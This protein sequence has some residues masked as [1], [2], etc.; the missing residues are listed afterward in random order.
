MFHKR[1]LQPGQTLSVFVHDM[2]VL[3]LH[4]IPGLDATARDELLVYQFLSGL[5]ASVSQQLRKS[6]EANSLVRAIE[7][8]KLLMSINNESLP[9]A[10]V[11]P[12]PDLLQEQI[13]K[14]MEQVAA[15][16]TQV[17]NK[18]RKSKRC[19]NCGQTGHM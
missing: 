3:L 12:K 6:G 19:Y 14:L 1:N 5:P 18:Q 9:V 17:T 4:A 8:D 15:L 13:K 11:A 7:R 10:V 2:K 16:S